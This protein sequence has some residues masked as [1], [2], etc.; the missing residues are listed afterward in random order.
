MKKTQT[1]FDYK[2]FVNYLTSIIKNI[3]KTLKMNF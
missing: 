2:N 3:D 1:F